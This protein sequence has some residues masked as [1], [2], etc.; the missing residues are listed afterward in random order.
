[1]VGQAGADP[2]NFNAPRGL[3]VAQDGTLFVADSRNNRIQHFSPDGTL[4][5]LG[6]SLATPPAKPRAVLQRAL[7][8]RRGSGRVGLCYRHLESPRPGIHLRGGV[9]PHVGLFWP[10]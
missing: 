3:A 9:Y 6:V 5:N 4:L 8:R 1:M 2:G 7:G 10:G